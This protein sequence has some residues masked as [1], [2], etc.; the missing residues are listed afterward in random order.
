M[1]TP[2]NPE[3]Q[4]IANRII[5]HIEKNLSN[6][7]DALNKV[8]HSSVNTIQDITNFRVYTPPSRSVIAGK[9]GISYSTLREWVAYHP[10]WQ[11]FDRKY[12]LM[13]ADLAISNLTYKA[14]SPFH[15]DSVK[16]N[17][18]ILGIMAPEM[19][20]EYKAEK[21]R[22]ALRVETKEAE[23]ILLTDK[24][25]DFFTA[26]IEVF[27]LFCRTCIRISNKDGLL[28]PFK[29][30]KP[31]R[32]LYREILTLV[33]EGRP[34]RMVILKAR[35]MG[36]TTLL[37][38]LNIFVTI[39]RRGMTG[40]VMAHD[41]DSSS[42][43][44]RKLQAM[45]DNWNGD[46]ML[47]RPDTIK[48]NAK[49]IEF[50]NRLGTGLC[51]T[52]KVY[53]AKK[54][55]IRG[56][57]TQFVHQ[58]E[59]AFYPDRIIDNLDTSVKQQVPMRPWTFIFYETTAD[60]EGSLF[61]KEWLD[62]VDAKE[63]GRDGFLPFFFPWYE[64]IGGENAEDDYSVTFR[65]ETERS[66]FIE[67]MGISDR[68]N[69]YPNEE[70][71]LM[72]KYGLSYEQLNWRRKNIDYNF[73][74]RVRK[75]DQ[76]Y[77]HCPEVAFISTGTNYFDL[78]KLSEIE[79]WA[80]TIPGTP[81][82]L[83]KIDGQWRM[84]KHDGGN[85]VV[86]K[87]PI[88]GRQYFMTVDPAEGEDPLCEV[89]SSKGEYDYHVIDV[90]DI[91]AR[92]QVAQYRGYTKL[93]ELAKLIYAVSSIY[94][95]ARYVEIAVERN[96]H[97][98]AVIQLLSKYQ[99][100]NLYYQETGLDELSQT[101]TTKVG[102]NT[103]KVSKHLAWDILDVAIC[104]WRDDVIGIKLRSSLTIAELRTGKQNPVKKTLSGYPH[105]DTISSASM[106][107]VIMYLRYGKN[108]YNVDREKDEEE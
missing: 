32:K 40:I 37:L 12:Q 55:E 78:K 33:Q 48:S 85:L 54:E 87:K 93:T 79:A 105:D 14:Q 102:W 86:W 27:P 58:S 101:Q 6:H 62:A 90:W 29:F 20:P 43:I 11:E 36:F 34:V 8:N 65:N 28:I 82:K 94:G 76:E 95:G 66:C 56:D 39:S 68:Y 57:T 73:K 17:Q 10:F 59:R 16:A 3:I 80:E 52:V 45:Y 71:Y 30:N 72:E 25:R 51:S 83:N 75:F 74:G 61:H 100:I 70:K 26:G 18:A 77:P 108:E 96:N 63:T 4:D 44:F 104:N 91:E 2:D 53:N 7:F 98:H 67:S 21:A 46:N 88:E 106:F 107:A 9:L 24:L 5:D 47:F 69:Q 38:A 89:K 13:F 81:V 22:L 42:S 1:F 92:E 35:Q 64:M 99:N 31:Q 23:L 103:T 97:G 15:K 49:M 60:G 84:L 19:T 50:N 41:L